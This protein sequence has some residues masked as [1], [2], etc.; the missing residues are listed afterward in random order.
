M[1][2]VNGLRL[3]INI[4]SVNSPLTVSQVIA[5]Y[6]TVELADSKPKTTLTR[7]VYTHH[8]DNVITPRWGN[9]PLQ[10]VKAVAVKK[11]LGELTVAPATKTKTKVVFGVLFQHAMRYEWAESNPI[12]LVRQTSKPLRDHDVLEPAEVSALFAELVDPFRT[13]VQ[14]ACMTGLRRVN[15]SV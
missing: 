6:K 11:W 12:R 7:K 15:C 5:H 2:A 14:T 9:H 4:Q 3:D 13:L 1:K 10:T 8:L